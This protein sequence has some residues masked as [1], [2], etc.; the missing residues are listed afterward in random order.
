M[1][2]NEDEDQLGDP[3]DGDQPFQEITEADLVGAGEAYAT[4]VDE[5][6]LDEPALDEPFLVAEQTVQLPTSPSASAIPTD[7]LQTR[8]ESLQV[9]AEDPVVIARQ[10]VLPPVS[11][12]EEVANSGALPRRSGKPS[13]TFDQLMA[14]DDIVLAEASVLPTLPARTGARWLS[15]V[16][17]TLL[18]PVIW[19][20]LSDS[21][22][23]LA[24]AVGNPWETGTINPAALIELGGGLLVLILV[25]VIAAQSS[26]GVIISGAL[27]IV[28]GLPFLAVPAYT[29]LFIDRFLEG[30]RDSSAFGGNVVGCLELTGFTGLLVSVGTIVL[31]LGIA[32]AF[33][34]KAGRREEATRAMV[35]QVNPGG[36][37]PRWAR[38]AS[39]D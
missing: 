20:L 28:V 14:S 16:V 25:A 18:T 7:V 9:Q 33:V 31:G 10:S 12:A 37:G 26:L 30:L 1:F 32:L 6:V 2:G 29:D 11:V 15:G 3:G 5:T 35:A 36:I 19:Y 17:I 22:A 34:R 38:K 4:T 24:F 8:T 21:A 13:Q 27:L 23:R 39:K